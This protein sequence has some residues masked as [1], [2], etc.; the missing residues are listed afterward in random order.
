M[1]FLAD[2]KRFNILAN[3]NIDQNKQKEFL[4][5]IIKTSK[6]NDNFFNDYI[7]NSNNIIEF[8]KFLNETENAIAK[9][10]FKE[11]V[12]RKLLEN[13]PNITNIN[14]ILQFKTQLAS[15]K[16]LFN[17]L[18]EIKK[19]RHNLYK[20]LLYPKAEFKSKDNIFRI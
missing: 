8:K 13:N 7:K 17:K 2:P 19:I 6:I 12:K 18:E 15:H 20:N 9:E 10:I 16:N 11:L 4:K 1:I 5:Y 14:Q 3:L